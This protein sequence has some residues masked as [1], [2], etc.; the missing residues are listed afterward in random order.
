MDY[1]KIICCQNPCEKKLRIAK[2]FALM[3]SLGASSPIVYLRLFINFVLT[4]CTNAI[5]EKHNYIVYPQNLAY[6]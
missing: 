1:Y 3:S 2:L 6:N 5:S 4:T